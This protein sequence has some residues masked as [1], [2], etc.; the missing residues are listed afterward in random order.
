MLS[1]PF[2]LLISNTAVINRNISSC[3]Q[4]RLST[5]LV[6]DLI[7]H[8]WFPLIC[9]LLTLS[10]S[11][12]NQSL[13]LLDVALSTIFLL[14]LI[15]KSFTLFLIREEFLFWG[16]NCNIEAA[17]NFHRSTFRWSFAIETT[18]DIKSKILDEKIAELCNINFTYRIL[19]TTFRILKAQ[20]W[21]RF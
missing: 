10:S 12:N 1:W 18:H 21:L 15:D 16:Y 13:V 2:S 6:I 3:T 4:Y 17:G 7:L 9:L 11:I 14:K 20:Y 8:T 5:N 19:N